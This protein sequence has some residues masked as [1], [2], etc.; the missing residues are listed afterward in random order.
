MALKAS[1]SC[2]CKAV[3][4]SFNLKAKHFDACHCGMCRS[5]GGGPALTV[6]SDGGIEFTGFE[7]VTLYDSSE[8]AQ[9]GFCKYCGSH[10]F[11]RLKDPEQGFCNFNLGTLDNQ[12][13][14]DFT[15][16]IYIDAKPNNYSFANSTKML[17]E[18]E[19]L[20]MFGLQ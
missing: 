18:K 2:L 16:Q 11:W 14:F 6:E 15:L 4:F 10:L 8:W 12:E 17:T 3:T 9:R 13:E 20:E 19:V 7:H 5:W 1:G